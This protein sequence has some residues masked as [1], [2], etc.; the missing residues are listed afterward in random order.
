MT[1][2]IIEEEEDFVPDEQEE[3]SEPEREK[4]Y[5]QRR[6]ARA[7]LSGKPV[8]RNIKQRP[9]KRGKRPRGKGRRAA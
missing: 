1:G 9:S 5:E 2:D 8:K 3:M 7:P 4:H 6:G